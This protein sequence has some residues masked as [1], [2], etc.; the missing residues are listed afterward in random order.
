MVHAGL[1]SLHWFPA[2]LQQAGPSYTSLNLNYPTEYKLGT[3]G[4][5][6]PVPTKKKRSTCHLSARADVYIIIFFDY[7]NLL[8]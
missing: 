6:Q 5:L 2:C 1:S 4:G 3:R 8:L 7:K